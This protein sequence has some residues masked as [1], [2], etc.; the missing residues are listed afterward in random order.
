MNVIFGYAKMAVN[1]IKLRLTL[2]V[3][4]PEKEKKIWKIRGS[5]GQ[6]SILPLHI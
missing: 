5:D 2:H 6:P 1:L 4:L 3:T